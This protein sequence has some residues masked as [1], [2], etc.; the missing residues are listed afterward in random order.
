MLYTACACSTSDGL[1]WSRA[2]CSSNRRL[3][4]ASCGRFAVIGTPKSCSNC[5]ASKSEALNVRRLRAASAFF[6]S[7][8]KSWNSVGKYSAIVI[9]RTRFGVGYSLRLNWR[10]CTF[11]VTCSYLAMNSSSRFRMRLI[12]RGLTKRLSSR[13]APN[14]RK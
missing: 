7:Y 2:S 13:I 12:L 3:T 5:A 14:C 4:A 8:K 9:S 10:S 11:V 6:G 1:V